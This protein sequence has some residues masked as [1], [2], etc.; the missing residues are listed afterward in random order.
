MDEL[1]VQ[2]LL[3]A[4]RGVRV[5]GPFPGGDV[6]EAVV[7]AQRLTL[8]GLV[9]GTEVPAATLPTVEGIATHQQAE[10]EEVVDSSRLLQGLVDAVATPGD[11]QVFLELLVQRGISDSAFSSPSAVRSIPQ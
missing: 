7:V 6:G 3:V 9:L 11:T 5:A 1:V 4:R 2:L 10:L 8:L